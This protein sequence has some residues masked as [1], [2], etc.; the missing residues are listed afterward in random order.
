MCC[1]HKLIGV[2]TTVTMQ[3]KQDKNNWCRIKIAGVFLGIWVEK[4][5]MKVSLLN[6]FPGNTN[7]MF[8]FSYCKNW[9]WTVLAMIGIYVP[10]YWTI[11]DRMNVEL[12][13]VMWWRYRWTYYSMT[14]THE[15]DFGDR[16]VFGVFFFSQSPWPRLHQ[17]LWQRI[18][19]CFC[20]GKK[21]LDFSWVRWSVRGFLKYQVAHPSNPSYG[22]PQ[23]QLSS[24]GEPQNPS[25]RTCN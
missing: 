17:L 1:L 5:T 16:L 19:V 12:K 20:S 25:Y 9:R 11:L 18:T 6:G 13:A 23:N 15:H 8:R 22:E 4:W 21:Q 7:G 14:Q 24:Y 2:A 3:L 10:C